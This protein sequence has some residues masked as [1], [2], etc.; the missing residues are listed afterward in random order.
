MQGDSP[1]YLSIGMESDTT[2]IVVSNDECEYRLSL[3]VL[4]NKE[5]VEDQS[6]YELEQPIFNSDGHEKEGSITIGTGKV[7][8]YEFQ[9]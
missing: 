5:E 8:V 6:F 1:L 2:D 4:S 7:G 9:L 3:I